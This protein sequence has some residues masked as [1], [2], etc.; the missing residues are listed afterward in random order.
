[1]LR[2]RTYLMVESN[3]SAL[4]GMTKASALRKILNVPGKSLNGFFKDEHW[5]PINNLFSAFG[6]ENIAF[7]IDKTEYKKDDS[8]NPSS[9]EWIITFPFK[10][11]KGKDVNIY[12]RIMASGAG[13]VNDPLKMYDVTF[14]AN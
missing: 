4:D 13:P 10:N 1:M 11:E 7:Q 5:L 3:G 8:G 12:G 9:K 14:T 6:K 2:K